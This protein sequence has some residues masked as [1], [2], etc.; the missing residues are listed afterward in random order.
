[1]LS[2]V[3][4]NLIGGGALPVVLGMAFAYGGLAQFM[5][6]MWEFRTGNT[7]GAA[8]FTTYGA[9]WLSFFIL[10]TYDLKLIT[11]LETNSALGAYLW[12]FG[13]I[14]GLFFLCTFAAPRG[15]QLV[16]LLLTITFILL[17]I[18]NSG[19]SS[20]IIHAGGWVGLATAAAAFYAGTAEIMAH[21]YGRDVLPL[22]RPR[23]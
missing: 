20:S 17:G 15:I 22:G 7:F 2:L 3:N 11:K 12:T 5:A 1:M 9:F 23:T 4:A 21:V 8:A 13:I 19:A 18:G 16:F 10:V 14:T 6:G